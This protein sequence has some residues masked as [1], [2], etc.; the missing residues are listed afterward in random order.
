MEDSY[1]GRKDAPIGSE[2]WKAL[3]TTMTEAA[4]GVLTGRRLLHIEGPYGLGLKAVPLPDNRAENGIINGN[5]L[6]VSLLH[7]TFSLNKRDIAAAEREGMPV[8]TNSVAA[9]AIEVAMQED[10][11]IFEGLRGSP[12]LLSAKGINEL[13]LATWDTIGKAVEDII[14]QYQL[15]APGMFSCFVTNKAFAG[16]IVFYIDNGFAQ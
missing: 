15:H 16:E 12:G 4:K 6:P 7:K 13:K 11:L 8:S 10:A 5:F 1:L 3:D 14:V 9:S 2:I